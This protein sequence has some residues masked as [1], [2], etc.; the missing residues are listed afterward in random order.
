MIKRIPATVIDNFFDNPEEIREYILSLEFNA[1]RGSYPGYRSEQIKF[2]NPTFYDSLRNRLLSI[3]YD[4]YR[5]AL[6]V[7]FEAQFQLI[8]EKFE[9]G[10]VHQDSDYSGRNLAGVIYLTPD[11]PLD[12][13]T[14]IYREIKS[15]NYDHLRYRNDFY[16]NGKINDI[17]KYRR[18]R[19]EFNSHYETVLDIKNVFN[20]LVIYDT[21]EFHKE[22]AFF[23]SSKEDSRLTIVFFMT[24]IPMHKSSFPLHRM[25]QN[26][27]L[28]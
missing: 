5:D 11:A 14:S 13:G 9:S 2:I 24:V 27:I 26:K 16:F 21:Y 1:P 8:P 6:D 22:S 28:L 4:Q 20:R 19:D 17:E 23:G 7:S 12:A 10:W 18:F 3:F 15:P 25:K